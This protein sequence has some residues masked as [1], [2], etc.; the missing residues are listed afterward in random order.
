[1]Y[2]DLFVCFIYITMVKEEEDAN[3]GGGSDM[4]CEGGRV[5]KGDIM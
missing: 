5:E 4:R 2:V 3:L 1:M